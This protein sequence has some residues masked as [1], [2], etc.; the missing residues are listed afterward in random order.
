MKFIAPI[1]VIGILLLQV[2]GAVPQSSVGGPM[3]LALAFFGAALA[4]GIHESWSN[5][6]GVLG[7][8]VSIVAALVGAMPALAQEVELPERS[9]TVGAR[10][11]RRRR[12][13]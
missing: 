2:S 4:V 8:I 7:W 9:E 1:A 12:G 5:K 13:G 11:G 10:G 3:T 6:R